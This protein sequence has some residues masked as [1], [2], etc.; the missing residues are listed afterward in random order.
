MSSIINKN[1]FIKNVLPSEQILG[2]KYDYS[3]CKNK[4]EQYAFVCPTNGEY[5]DENGAGKNPDNRTQERFDE[6]KACGFDVLLIL[7]NDKYSGEDFNSSQ[8]K[9][10]LDM[11]YKS[12]LKTVVYDSRLHDLSARD[13]AI[14]GDVYASME[15]LTAFVKECMT[16]Y[17]SH[18]AFYGVTLYD[19]PRFMH[20]PAVGEITRAVKAV[21]ENIF[22]HTCLLPYFASVDYGL[23][24]FRTSC[25]GAGDEETTTAYKRYIGEHL[26][27]TGANYV[28]Y[29]NYPIFYSRGETTICFTYFHNLQMTTNVAKAHGAKIDLTIQ[30]YADFKSEMRWCDEDDIRFQAMAALA[31]ACCNISYFTY[32]MFPWRTNSGICQAI[33]DDKGNKLCYYETQRVNELCQKLYAVT[34]NFEYAGTNLYT[35]GEEPQLFELVERED[36][37]SIKSVNASVPTLCNRL[38]DKERGVEAFMLVNSSDPYKKLNDVVEIEFNNKSK[39]V[40]YV[41][42][43]P[44]YIGLDDGKLSL[45]ISCGDGVIIIPI[46]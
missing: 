12:G 20:L 33:M 9:K 15:E 36:F 4:M 35:T 29:D 39:A 41:N 31:F 18:P 43:T 32:W 13:K 10:N 2:T 8:L 16:P 23:L 46:D 40:V 22:V 38:F 44:E 45:N 19:E 11:A 24:D 17:M 7:G 14:V 42:G 27:R 6:Y 25:D 28:A 5:S 26:D 37:E 34:S 30:T 21:D 1:I 3:N